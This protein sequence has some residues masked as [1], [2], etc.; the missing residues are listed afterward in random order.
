MA[1]MDKLMKA[2]DALKVT[3]PTS[4]EDAILPKYVN[5]QAH[6]TITKLKFYTVNCLKFLWNYFLFRVYACTV[7]LFA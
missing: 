5:F 7:I 1:T 3:Q 4:S 6:E 2:L